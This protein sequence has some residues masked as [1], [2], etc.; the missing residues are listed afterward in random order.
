MV[1]EGGG[2]GFLGLG[3]LAPANPFGKSESEVMGSTGMLASKSFTLNFLPPDC[4]LASSSSSSPE[5][6]VVDAVVVVV[7]EGLEHS[8]YFDLKIPLDKLVMKNQIPSGCCGR[9]F[10]LGDKL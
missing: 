5:F 2:T 8:S 3:L 7:V 9:R 10:E 6:E 4:L 1:E